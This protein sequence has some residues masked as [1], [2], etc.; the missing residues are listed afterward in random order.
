M[1]SDLERWFHRV[2]E[3]NPDKRDGKE[4]LD[5]LKEI[6]NAKFLTV[7]NMSTGKSLGYN[8]K[9]GDPVKKLEHHIRTG[10]LGDESGG[11]SGM[12]L[13]LENGKQLTKDH[14][15]VAACEVCTC[16]CVCVCDGVCS[17]EVGTRTYIHTH[18]H[19]YCILNL[20]TS[21][22]YRKIPMC[23]CFLSSRSAS[24]SAPTTRSP[25]RGSVS[26]L[27]WQL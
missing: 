10:M 26:G 16:V 22:P 13:L 25:F 19:T 14:S 18:T 1:A 8:V 24:G 3:T 15:L 9:T 2:L 11:P 23:L 7:V 12:F 20:F 17:L 5:V 27:C 4:S 6:V 21:H